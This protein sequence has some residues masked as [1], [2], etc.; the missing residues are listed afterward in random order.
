MSN[1]TLKFQ[2]QSLSAGL[3]RL[4]PTSQTANIYIEKESIL[5]NDNKLVFTSGNEINSTRSSC[6]AFHKRQPR[7]LALPVHLKLFVWQTG[8]S[9]S[10]S[11]SLSLSISLFLSLYL[12]PKSH[13]ILELTYPTKPKV[14]KNALNDSSVFRFAGKQVIVPYY[15]VEP[16][17]SSEQPRDCWRMFPD[18]L[19]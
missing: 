16:P 2:S 4:W 12:V 18:S 17:T 10:L 9:R 19:V 7:G 3:I 11:L 5:L 13:T 6:W 14:N 15:F 1:L 8:W